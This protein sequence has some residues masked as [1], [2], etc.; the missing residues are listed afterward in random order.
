MNIKTMGHQII[1]YPNL[2]TNRQMIKRLEINGFDL[3]ELQLPYSEPVA[4]GPLFQMANQEALK[5]G[6]TISK[7]IDFIDEQVQRINVPIYVMT[8]FNPIVAYGEKEFVRKMA[9]IG[10]KGLIV[11]DAPHD[12]SSEFWAL[13]KD[14]GL[15]MIPIATLNTEENRV[16]DMC[17]RGSGFL[18]FVPRLG[19]TGTRSKID[20]ELLG[21]LDALKANASLPVGVGFGLEERS[22]LEALQ[23]H[24]DIAIFGSILLKTLESGGLEGVDSLLASLTG[25]LNHLYQKVMANQPLTEVEAYRLMDAILSKS[26]GDVKTAAIL[27]HYANHLPSL[28]ELKGFIKS[29]KSVQNSI[30]VPPYEV[31]DNCGTGGD[32]IGSFNIS[33]T[34]A[35]VA[36]AAGVRVAKHGNRAMTSLCGGIDVLEKLGIGFK[37]TGRDNNFMVTDPGNIEFYFAQD[38]HPILKSVSSIRKTLGFKT[39]FNLMGPLLSPVNAN[40]QLIGVYEEKIMPLMA[41]WIAEDPKKSALLVHGRDGLDELSISGSSLLY[42]IRKGKITKLEIEPEAFGL[43]TYPI[44]AIKGGTPEDNVVI[45]QNVL[46]GKGDLAKRQIVQLNAGAAIYLYGICATFEEAVARAGEIIHSG[47]GFECLLALRNEAQN[48]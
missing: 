22:D 26:L 13:C 6:M 33:T 44:E 24:C 19:V 20:D 32:G 21:R 30:T 38:C 45:L 9:E 7:A 39:I 37:G 16:R 18:Y 46:Q 28:A 25:M 3:I 5:R 15:D 23:G 41:Q 34:A 40:Y 12:Q 35:F 1:G 14:T 2:E 36:A 10:I 8:Y 47:K 43:G 31:L 48:A 4:D 27:S 11:P 42:E 17:H 29:V